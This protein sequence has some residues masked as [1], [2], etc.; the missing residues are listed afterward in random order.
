MRSAVLTVAPF[1]ER[2]LQ[3]PT[4]LNMNKKCL[5]MSCFEHLEGSFSAVGQERPGVLGA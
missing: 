2:C 1:A 3:D 5:A 4:S